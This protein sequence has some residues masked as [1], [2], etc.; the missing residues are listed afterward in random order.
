MD[1]EGFSKVKLGFDI[2]AYDG[3]VAQ[4]YIDL[5]VETLVCVEP[6]PHTY[7]RLFNRFTDNTNVHLIS[8]VMSSTVTPDMVFFTSSRH[9][10][11]STANKDFI[12]NSRYANETDENGV[13]FEWDHTVRV[14]TTTIDELITTY[15]V[16]Q[17]IKIDT[18][19]D[20]HVTLNGLTKLYPDTTIMFK[21]R[22]EFLSNTNICLQY[23]RKL[24]YNKFGLIEGDQVGDLPNKYHDIELFNKKLKQAFPEP[25]NNFLG[26][27]FTKY[28]NK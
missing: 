18:V 4:A 26:T 7:Y 20:E 8:K 9:P 2:G 27:I 10:T 28:E 11:I 25:Q 22:E 6:D 23:L 3:G 13:P 14:D 16:P 12:T 17:F 5:G 15:G 19:G 24:G 21:V 1:V